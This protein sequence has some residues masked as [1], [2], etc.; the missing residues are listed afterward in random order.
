MTY[1]S[2]L[3]PGE[4]LR[5]LFDDVEFSYLVVVA[6]GR[7]RSSCTWPTVD[8]RSL[9][10]HCCRCSVALPCHAGACKPRAVSGRRR[11]AVLTYAAGGA[12]A[13]GRRSQ[14]SSSGTVE[15]Q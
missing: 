12:A 7:C 14:H 15:R 10:G 6:T 2:A 8:R 11:P 1:T 9:R 13:P 4:Y 3:E 5:R